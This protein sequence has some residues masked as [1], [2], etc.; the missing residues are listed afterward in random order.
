[1]SQPEL[2]Q[3]LAGY[4]ETL[5]AAEVAALLRVHER[6]VQRWARDGRLSS[7]RV[8]RSYRFLRAEVLRWMHDATIPGAHEPS[9]HPL[10]P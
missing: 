9:R 1:M 7:V 5:T 2:E 6:S 4:P 10:S 3:L 8:G